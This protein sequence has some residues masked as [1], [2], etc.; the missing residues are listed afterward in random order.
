[1]TLNFTS[2]VLLTL[3]KNLSKVIVENQKSVLK[4]TKFNYGMGRLSTLQLYEEII[5]LNQEKALLLNLKNVM[6]KAFSLLDEDKR[7]IYLRFIKNIK[8]SEIA[9]MLGIS[10]RQVFR[11]YDIALSSFQAQLEYLK[12]SADR[13]ENEF[14]EL[15]LY[16]CTKMRLSQEFGICGEDEKTR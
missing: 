13:I 15:K 12:Y 4:R 10:M 2:K 8:F 9:K 14:G 11:V 16:R 7:I 1:M 6:D 3:Y 5:M